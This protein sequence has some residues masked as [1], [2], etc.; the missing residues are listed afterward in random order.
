MDDNPAADRQAEEQLRRIA[1]RAGFAHVLFQYEP[2]AAALTYEQ[3][4]RREEVVLVADLGGGTADFAVIRLSPQRHTAPDRTAD[5][6]G[7]TG[8]HIGGTDLDRALGFRELMPFL[9]RGTSYRSRPVDMPNAPYV[10]LST[11]QLIN[12]LYTQ[13]SMRDIGAMVQE[14]ADPERVSR[15]LEVVDKRCG[16]ALLEKVEDAKIALTHAD[17]VRTDFSDLLADL[18]VTFARSS[19]VEAIADQVAGIRRTVADL[20]R[21]VGTHG[22]RIHTVFFTGGTSAVPILR[23]TILSQLPAAQVV[24][25]DPVAAVGYGLALDAGRRIA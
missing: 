6:L 16:H 10:T 13:K 7:N 2:I 11:W 17:Q 22:D 14:A 1:N 5:I 25:G 3:T 21:G 23:D 18:H 19:F 12:L 4:L 15:L 8:V 9:G 24:D 20:L